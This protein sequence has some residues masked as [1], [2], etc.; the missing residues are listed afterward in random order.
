MNCS[1]VCPHC[2][3]SIRALGL[4][5][6]SRRTPYRCAVCGGESV[7]PPR[8]GMRL[9]LGWGLVVAVPAAALEHLDVG[10]VFLFLFC[11]VAS[12]TIPLLFA[13]FC[14]FEA[15]NTGAF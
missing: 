4:L 15:K 7:I 1:G 5:R 3:T 10:P 12:G 9:V 2:G 13:R 14:R 6:V 8:S 11:A